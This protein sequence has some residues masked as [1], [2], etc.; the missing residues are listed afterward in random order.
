[1]LIVDV[2]EGETL[3]QAE[4]RHRA[5]NAAPRNGLHPTMTRAQYDRLAR[6]NF[7][8]LKH[9]GRSPLHYR[10][11]EMR[12][13]ENDTLAR[14]LGRVRHRAIFEPEK[15]KAEVAVWRGGRRAGKE[16]DSFV[17]ANEAREIITEDEYEAVVV[18]A[19]AVRSDPTAG[20]YLQGGRSEA[21]V[22][23]SYSQQGT[24]ALPG[25]SFDCKGRLDFLG[26][27]IVDLKTCRDASP[28][29]FGRHVWNYKA[30]VQAAWYVD[31]VRAAT[32]KA[33]PY[34][35]I[36]VENVAPFAVQVYRVPEPILDLG[37]DEYRTWLDRLNFCR[38]ESQW[39]AY[40]DGELDLELPT[41]ATPAG[42]EDSDL[43]DLGITFQPESNA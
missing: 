8:T 9:I 5:K 20:K 17:E 33:L 38:T 28:A 24:E 37:R 1:M 22:L 7:S 21:S 42:D 18:L 2:E 25:Y 26:A 23:W 39:P 29:G 30:H 4:A 6:V 31:G 14:K 12:L 32:G 19:H 41:W 34:V 3:E 27:A 16:W 15:M 35:L 43:S 13:N 40:A 10:A 11:Q 36:A